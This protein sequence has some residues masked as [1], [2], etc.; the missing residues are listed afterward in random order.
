MNDSRGEQKAAEEAQV[1]SWGPHRPL[2]GVCTGEF[3]GNVPGPLEVALWEMLRNIWANFGG[4]D[5][6]V[7]HSNKSHHI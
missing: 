1:P 2:D 5:N 3:E 7:I 6:W 4:V